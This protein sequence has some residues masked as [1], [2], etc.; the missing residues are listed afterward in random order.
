MHGYD[1]N[2]L[3][4]DNEVVLARLKQYF[5]VFI[6]LLLRRADSE[7]VGHRGV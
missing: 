7:Q 6:L 4:K 2:T 1:S 5:L 3:I